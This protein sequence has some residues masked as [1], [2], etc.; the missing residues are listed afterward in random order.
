[1]AQVKRL[2]AILS[3]FG[4]SMVF[5]HRT[6]APQRIKL[7]SSLIACLP[8]DLAQQQKADIALSHTASFAHTT[9]E[10][11]GL[12][13]SYRCYFNLPHDQVPCVP[14]GLAVRNKIKGAPSVPALSA[15]HKKCYFLGSDYRPL[16]ALIAKKPPVSYKE[17]NGRIVNSMEE[18]KKLLG[19]KK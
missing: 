7:I 3:I 14:K 8:A 13:P 17:Y 12:V 4:L 6:R 11:T 2:I 9:L 5:I 16:H 19:S 15:L 10:Q 18:A 1:M